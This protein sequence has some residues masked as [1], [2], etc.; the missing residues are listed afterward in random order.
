MR[1][2]LHLLHH[3]PPPVRCHAANLASENVHADISKLIA[4]NKVDANIQNM[5]CSTTFD[6]A[7]YGADDDEKDEVKSSL[8][9]AAKEGSMDGLKSLLEREQMSTSK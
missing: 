7:Q 1:D 8:H 6:A 2:S 3:P 9:V 4:E 5:V